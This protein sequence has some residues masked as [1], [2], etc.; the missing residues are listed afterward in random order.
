M[1]RSADV[2]PASAAHHGLH[3]GTPPKEPAMPSLLPA[4]WSMSAPK[5]A[6]PDAALFDA[7]DDCAIGFE[8]AC[9]ALQLD[10]WDAPSAGDSTQDQSFN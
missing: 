5:S 4:R 10:G 2:P 7:S 1:R 8:A 3:G 6:P 9:P